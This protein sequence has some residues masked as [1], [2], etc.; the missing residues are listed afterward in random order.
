MK[1]TIRLGIPEIYDLWQDLEAKAASNTLSKDE[2]VLYKKWG[3]A[4][5]HLSANPFHTGLNTHDIPSLTKRYGQKV[6]QS[7]LENNTSRAM[8]MYW[9]YGPNQQEI[10]IIGLE[11]HP[12]DS[13]NGSYDKITLS[14]AP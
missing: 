5:A 10:T 14:E 12:E 9:I 13:K 4:M 3:K 7:Y 2:A 1:F 11:P 8:R 6:W